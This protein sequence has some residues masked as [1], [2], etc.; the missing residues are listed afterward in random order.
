MAEKEVKRKLTPS[1]RLLEKSWDVVKAN[2]K[3]FLIINSVTVVIS[4][5]SFLAE[6]GKSEKSSALLSGGTGP[7]GAAFSALFTLG[8]FAFIVFMVLAVIYAV[9]VNCLNLQLAQKK[10]PTIKGVWNQARPKIADVFFVSLLSGLL[11]IGGLILF[12]VPGIIMFRRYY[13]AP[14]FVIDK[15][16]GVREAMAQSAAASK[17]VSGY[18]YGLVGVGIV[19]GLP[20]IIP[21]VGPIIASALALVYSVAPA[22]RYE[23]IKDLA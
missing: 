5:F 10:K 18:I 9:V 22:L 16:L 4:V 23:E 19:L 14:Y 21:L 7:E 6:I 12:I 20:N 17:P 3:V 11:I 13:L 1:F 2:W 15:N 8:I